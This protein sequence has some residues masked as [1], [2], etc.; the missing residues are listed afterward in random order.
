MKITIVN[1]FNEKEIFTHEPE[2][3]NLKNTVLE[4]IKSDAD[5]S[6]ADLSCADLSDADLSCADLSG[7]DLSGADLSCADLSD[8]D[9]SGADLSDADL[10]DADLR[11]YKNDMFLVLIYAI[12]EIPNLIR[13]IKEGKIDGSTCTGECCCLCGTLEKSPVSQI[14]NRVESVRDSSRPIEMFFA[15]IKKGDTPETS[16]NAKMALEWCEE[17]LGLIG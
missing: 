5:L 15:T 6:G 14:T 8:A 11:I 16:Y 4:A 10:S 13:A 12:S 7:A 2:E 17:F 9:L 3:N 1:R